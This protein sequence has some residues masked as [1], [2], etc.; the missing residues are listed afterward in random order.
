M[1][2]PLRIGLVLDYTQ[3]YPREVLFGIRQFAETRPNWILVVHE[4]SEFKSRTLRAM[5]P[6]GVIALVV[7]Q[8]LADV[9]KSQRPVVNVSFVLRDSPFPRVG[10]DNRQVG[11]LAVRHLCDRGL[12]HFGF[13]GHAEYFYSAERE[14][15]FR[16]TLDEMGCHSCTCYHER[17][18]PSYRQ[19]GRLLALSAGLQ[20]WLRGLPKPVGVFAY[21][22]LWAVQLIEA[23]RM[24]SLHVP[25]DVAVVGV[26]NDDLLCRLSRPALSSI[27]LPGER[28]GWEAAALLDRL[29]QGAKPPKDSILIPPLGVVARRSSEVLPTSDP[30]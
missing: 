28:V 17:P 18:G 1:A 19:R 25:D 30:N 5:Q 12:R 20:R 21:H 27:V 23:C 3:G 7:S 16:E 2:A 15:G 24:A 22:D 13:A 9:L 29:L 26:D 10:V 8:K 6:D 4:A 14:A 11:R